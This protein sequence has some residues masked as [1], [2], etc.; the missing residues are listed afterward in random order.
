MQI[1][2]HRKLNTGKRKYLKL[3]TDIYIFPRAYILYRT[4]TFAQGFK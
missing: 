3:L 1:C 4:L 2:I